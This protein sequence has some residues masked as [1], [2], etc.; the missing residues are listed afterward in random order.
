LLA[1]LCTSEVLEVN[2]DTYEYNVHKL[3]RENQSFHS[4]FKYG[5]HFFLV[6]R[7]PFVLKWRYETGEV[8]IYD[9]MPSGFKVSK[10][11]DWVFYMNNMKPYKNKLILP[12]G[13]TNM[14]L[15]FDLDTC[16]FKKL[17]VFDEILNRKLKSEGSNALSFSTCNF[18]SDNSLYFVH[19]NEVLYRYDF[20][21]QAIETVCDIIPVFTAEACKEL[22]NNFVDSMLRCENSQVKIDENLPDGQSGKRIYHYIKTK[23]LKE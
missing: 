3:G 18:V 21:S 5:D 13:F 14:V 11:Q 7:Q 2:L 19:K 20:Q 6:G 22:N 15:E 9:K 4:I 8:K 12:G 17:D 10:K 16:E 23:V 1:S